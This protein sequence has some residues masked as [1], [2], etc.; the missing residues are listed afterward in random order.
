MMEG[1]GENKTVMNAETKRIT[2]H[3]W[4][5]LQLSNFHYKSSYGR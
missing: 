5:T 4:A 3:I 1:K 2:L